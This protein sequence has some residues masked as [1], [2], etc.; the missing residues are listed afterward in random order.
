MSIIEIEDRE[1][2]TIMSF[3]IKNT[4]EEDIIDMLKGA[5]LADV[6]SD[7]INGTDE[8]LLRIQQL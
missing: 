8:P 2:N 7:Y 4:K 5:E 6:E 1:G 3:R